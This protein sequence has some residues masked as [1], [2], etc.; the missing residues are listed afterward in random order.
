ML[1]RLSI[2]IAQLKGG[3]TLKTYLMKSVIHYNI[4]TE[5]NKLLKKYTKI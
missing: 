3:N 1:W 4:Y 2:A 5:Q